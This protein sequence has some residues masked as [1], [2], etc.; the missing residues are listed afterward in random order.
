MP[1]SI[2]QIPDLFVTLLSPIEPVLNDNLTI[3]RISLTFTEETHNCFFIYSFCTSVL[4]R[5]QRKSVIIAECKLRSVA[6]TCK[7]FGLKFENLD[8]AAQ[9]A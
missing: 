1:N 9:A 3:N 4:K 8:D 6:S 7:S 5:F 2:Q